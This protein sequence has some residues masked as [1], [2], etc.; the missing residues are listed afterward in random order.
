MKR[1]L[2][3]V[4]VALCLSVLNAFADS[5]PP[6]P[7][8]DMEPDGDAIQFFG[9]A[10]FTIQEFNSAGQPNCTRGGSDG[11][12]CFYELPTLENFLPNNQSITSVQLSFIDIDQ[13]AFQVAANLDPSG[14]PHAIFTTE[15]TVV[16]GFVELFT[17]STVAPCVPPILAEVA[18]DVP[19]PPC[20]NMQTEAF[21]IG[22]ADPI[23]GADH[24]LTLR[25]DAN[26][27]EPSTALLIVTG[28]GA[29]WPLRRRLAVG[30]KPASEATGIVGKR[31][32]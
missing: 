24:T 20:Q 3:L 25:V 30:N 11:Q 14:F 22:I 8:I 7:I 12:F 5:T 13:G 10:T 27:P 23:F 15:Q 21:H 16:P 2:T 18:A 31:S 32:V 17:G 29:L 4:A 9:S 6:D 28:V 26:V 1:A 19:P